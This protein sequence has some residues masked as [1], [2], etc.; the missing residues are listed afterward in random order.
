MIM[1]ARRGRDS[2]FAKIELSEGHVTLGPDFMSWHCHTQSDP[3]THYSFDDRS[4]AR[5]ER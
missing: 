3:K 4:W 1:R 5:V 2:E